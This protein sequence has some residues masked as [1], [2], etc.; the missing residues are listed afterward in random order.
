M[1]RLLTF[2]VALVSGPI[3]A[4]AHFYP[5]KSPAADFM[6]YYYTSPGGLGRVPL[7]YRIYHSSE[8]SQP[9]PHPNSCGVGRTWDGQKCVKSKP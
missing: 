3:V 4:N 2:A 9:I 1:F 8:I 7:R 5:F 6:A